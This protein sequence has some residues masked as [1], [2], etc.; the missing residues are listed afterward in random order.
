MNADPESLV[1]LTSADD[2]FEANTIVA[3]LQDAGID[4]V[5][6]GAVRGSLPLGGRLLR[7]PVQVRTADLER[8]RAIL[9]ANIADS[10][11]LEWDEIDI[12]RREDDLP[13]TARRQWP[14]LFQVGFVVAVAALAVAALAALAALLRS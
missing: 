1:T 2:E 13:L 3:V 6:F 5:A 14:M 4:A 10:V 9:Q 8:A 11:D 12:G 7:V